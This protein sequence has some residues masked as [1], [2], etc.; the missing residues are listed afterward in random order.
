MEVWNPTEP[1]LIEIIC[2]L[3]VANPAEPQYLA[4]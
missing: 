4:D 3:K 1:R 2:W